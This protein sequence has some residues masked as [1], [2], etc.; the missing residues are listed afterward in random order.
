MK[1]QIIVG[2]TNSQ[3]KQQLRHQFVDLATKVR[4]ISKY[5]FVQLLKNGDLETAQQWV[6]KLQS[7]YDFLIDSARQSVNSLV[8]QVFVNNEFVGYVTDFKK[9]S[10]RGVNIT[11]AN[12]SSNILSL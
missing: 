8:A 5:E 4:D 11:R 7:T 2:S 12:V 6:Q 3:T 1:K 9:N 10:A